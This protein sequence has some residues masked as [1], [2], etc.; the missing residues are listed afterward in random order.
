V[1]DF[2]AWAGGGERRKEKES[3]G[4]IKWTCT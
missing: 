4:L 2:K 1:K 3:Q